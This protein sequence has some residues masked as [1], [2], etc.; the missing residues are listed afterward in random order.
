MALEEINC[1]VCVCVRVSDIDT[2]AEDVLWRLILRGA[3]EIILY[4]RVVC[5]CV[6]VYI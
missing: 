6:Y 5:V 1:V 2:L 4:C 3:E